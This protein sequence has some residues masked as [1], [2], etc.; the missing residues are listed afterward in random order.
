MVRKQEEEIFSEVL[1]IVE[2]I[3]KIAGEVIII[4][5]LAIESL[6]SS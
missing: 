4:D 2:Y 1:N 6:G 5:E 3:N